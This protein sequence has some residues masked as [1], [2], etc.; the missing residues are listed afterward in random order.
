VKIPKEVTI[1]QI[2]H[3]V[4]TKPEVVVGKTLCRGS[5]DEDNYTITI[6]Q[7]NTKRGYVY[8]ADE[9]AE[10]FWHELTHAILYDMN[11]KL[12]HDED[13]VTDFSKRLHQ[14]ISTARF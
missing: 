10:T 14:A 1:G 12:T 3:L 7:G 6:A 2:P 13:F 9:R 5:F 4:C 11:N 8:E